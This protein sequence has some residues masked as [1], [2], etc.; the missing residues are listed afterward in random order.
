M[1]R[2]LRASAS[3]AYI[4]KDATIAAARTR[5]SFFEEKPNSAEEWE[6]ASKPTNAQGIMASN[7]ADNR[8]ERARRR[9][10]LRARH[11]ERAPTDGKAEGEPPRRKHRQ[12]PPDSNLCV[13]VF[14]VHRF[15]RIA[16]VNAS[17]SLL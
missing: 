15:P 3:M 14:A 4:A 6:T 7:D 8:S 2:D 12:M 10:E 16:V 13:S 17:T 9:Q 5:H 11:H 1:L